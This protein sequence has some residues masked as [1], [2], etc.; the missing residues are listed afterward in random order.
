[1]FFYHFNTERSIQYG[2]SL[3]RSL[4]REMKLLFDKYD[5][6]ISFPQIVLNEPIEYQKATAYEKAQADKFYTEQKVQAK[7]HGLLSED[8]VDDEQR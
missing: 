8:G 2:V 4:N 7:Q 5:I 6:N 1:M 3:E